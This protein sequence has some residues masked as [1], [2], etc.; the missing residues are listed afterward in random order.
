MLALNK[1]NGQTIFELVT[2]LCIIAV[3]CAIAATSFAAILKKE[4]ARV[5][6]NRMATATME[7]R[8][9]ALAHRT[10]VTLCPSTDGRAC[11]GEW[12]G[13]LISFV[14][15]SNSDN[16]ATISSFPPLPDGRIEW[17]AF[18]QSNFLQM[19]EQGMTLAQ[20]GSFI[21][22]PDDN[23]ARFA[24]ALIINKSGR[25][26]TAEDYNGDGIREVRRGEPI[27]CRN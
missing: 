8:R 5:A 6:I 11:S 26:R 20:N 18:R 16:F 19:Q 2:V 25:A 1:S 10:V 4:K 27:S 13:R 9:Y 23:D 3:L 12:Q 21:Y 15:S 7:A 22:C 14:G 17:R 24:H